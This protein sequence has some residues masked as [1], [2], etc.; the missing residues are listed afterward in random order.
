MGVTWKLSGQQQ[1]HNHNLDR[2]RM[3]SSSDISRAKVNYEGDNFVVEF[4]VAE[5]KPEELHIKTEGDTLIVS[6]KQES[7]TST[8]KSYVSKQFEQRFSLPSGVNP[9][10]I[11]SKLGVDGMLRISAPREGGG[12]RRQDYGVLE[13]RSSSSSRS[14][15]SNKTEGLP[16]PVIRNDKDKFEIKIDVSEYS[17]NDLDVKVENNNLVI[18]AKQ[19]SRDQSGTI[20]SRVFE[21]KF[22]LPAGIV[23]DSVKSNLSREGVLVITAD[24]ETTDTSRALYT[25][26]DKDADTRSLQNKMDRVLTPSSWDTRRESAFDDVRR[27]SLSDEKRIMSAFDDLRRDSTKSSSLFDRSLLDDKS[28]FASN[29]E[30][31]GISQ[32]E[33]DDKDYKILVNVD[34]YTPEELVIKTV[35]N[36]VVVEA[37]HKEKT[38]DG[39][40]YSTQSF[41]QSFTLPRGVD[42]DS[43]K[44]SLSPQGVLTISAPIDKPA[45]V[46]QERLVPIKHI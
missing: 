43:V 8:G 11:S 7:K 22:S 5:Y 40:S 14:L 23:T 28:I 35:D 13:D 25:K 20:R 46:N 16:E 41:S 9:E 34:K 37:K 3:S 4:N 27:D 42:P 44:S 36:T 29:S 1:Q 24:R 33:Y 18:C 15:A 26:L 2:I 10:K 30:Q 31:S 38:S 21:Q 19:E 45:R 17:P 32:V 6:A 39:R 12:Y